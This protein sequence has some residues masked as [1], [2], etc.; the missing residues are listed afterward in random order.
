MFNDFSVQIGSNFNPTTNVADSIWLEYERVIVKSLFTSFGLDYL[1]VNDQ[2][3]GDVD[4]IHNVRQMD[5]DPNMHFKSE[6][7]RQA[8]ENRGEY[9][10]AKYHSNRNFAKA[11]QHGKSEY[12]KKGSLDDAYTGGKLGFG[13]ECESNARAELDHIVSCKEIHDDRGRVLANLSGEELA[14]S[15][16]NLAWTNKHLNASKKEASVEDYIA[17]HPELDDKTIQRLRKQDKKSRDRMDQKI[18]E[19]YYTSWN[20]LSS[21][22]VAALNVG[23]RRGLSQALGLVFAEVWCSVRY[24]VANRHQNAES[25]LSAVMDGLKKGFQNAKEKFGEILEAG[26]KGAFSGFLSSLTTTLINIFATTAQRLIKLIRECWSYL[27]EAGSILI[28]NPDNLPFQQRMKEGAKIIATGASVVCGGLVAEYLGKLGVDAL[29]FGLGEVVT[30]FC[31]VAVSGLLTIT[32]LRALDSNLGIEKMVKAIKKSYG[33]CADD[34]EAVK[35][36]AKLFEEYGLRYQVVSQQFKQANDQYSPVVTMLEQV[37]SMVKIMGGV[38]ATGL[39][40][41]GE[42]LMAVALFLSTKRLGIENPF[43]KKGY[44][45]FMRDRNARMRFK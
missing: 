25:F 28:F 6:R 33:S 40:L 2:Y 36:Q 29:P 34:I 27:I 32:F 7:N 14:N 45:S 37:W 9:D 43:G 18:N 3:G 35:V 20:F 15:D 16:E 26:L 13:P 19:A 5:S 24:E 39:S 22:T 41:A 1:L 30:T 44:K 31:S 10:S 23:C 4:T 11:K 17:K 21:T 42:K 12:Q 38:S 8:Y